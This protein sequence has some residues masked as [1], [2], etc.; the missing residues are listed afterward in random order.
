VQ[1]ATLWLL[2]GGY[3]H[4]ETVTPEVDDLTVTIEAARAPSSASR[5]V[6]SSAPGKAHEWWAKQSHA[7]HRIG[8]AHILLTGHYHH[9]RAHEE[10]GRLWLQS[11]TVDPG[12]PWYDQKHGGVPGPGGVVTFYTREGTWTGLELL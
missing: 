1:V 8:Q 3:E 11:G 5:T 6:T 12:S 9:L 4:V 10:S 2:A 7:R